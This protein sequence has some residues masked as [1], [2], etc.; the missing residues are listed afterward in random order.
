MEGLGAELFQY[1]KVIKLHA[2]EI[3]HKVADHHNHCPWTSIHIKNIL[4][5]V[6]TNMH[7]CNAKTTSLENGGIG[8]FHRFMMTNAKVL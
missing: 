2:V 3:K 4:F 6:P 8:I 5:P 1:T 7:L